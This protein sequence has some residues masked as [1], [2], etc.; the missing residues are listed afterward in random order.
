M[1]VDPAEFNTLKNDFEDLVDRVETLEDLLDATETGSVLKRLA[2][3]ESSLVSISQVQAVK[4]VLESAIDANSNSLDAI[5]SAIQDLQNSVNS[6]NRFRV[7][8]RNELKYEKPSGDVAKTTWTLDNAYDEDAA[9]IVFQSN[10]T[11]V[12]PGLITFSDPDSG[13]FTSSVALTDDVRVIYFTALP[14]DD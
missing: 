3:L 1:P 9:F 14:S 11:L 8:L 7:D 6:I 2:D 13:E 10:L 12:D 4:S 5:D